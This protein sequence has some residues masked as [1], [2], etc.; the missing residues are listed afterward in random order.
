MF[1]KDLPRKHIDVLVTVPAHNEEKW[2]Y[3]TVLSLKKVLENERGDFQLSIAEDGSTD[4]TKTVL[5]RLKSEYP[6][7]IIQSRPERLGRGNALRSLWLS[8]DADHYVFV[9]ADLAGDASG[10]VEVVRTSKSGFDVVTGS[11]YVRG[12]S[13]NRPPAR[14]L[15]SK[16]YNQLVRFVFSESVQDHQCGLKALSRRAR[17]ELLPICREDSWAWDTEVLVIAS[18]LGYEVI[19]VPV[20]WTERRTTKTP[21]MR[22]FSDLKLH[23]TALLR[24]RGT[25]RRTIE[26]SYSSR[27]QNKHGSL[28]VKQSTHSHKVD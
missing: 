11:R 25:L 22:L 13:V 20:R 17:D 12:A 26:E 2:L 1:D 5:E 28:A 18:H 3:E 14:W 21:W 8:V 24:L 6:D 4:S 10:L 19:E 27:P 9:D 15:V 7:I 16:F 23:G